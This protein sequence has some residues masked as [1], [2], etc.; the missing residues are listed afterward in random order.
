MERGATCESVA[1]ARR[2][3]V[4]ASWHDETLTLAF[5][6]G[7]LCNSDDQMIDAGVESRSR[8]W[9]YTAE[10]TCI[11]SPDASGVQLTS[12]ETTPRGRCLRRGVAL[13]LNVPL[14][15]DLY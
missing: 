15:L 9:T 8:S 10:T 6:A 13:S 11:R 1:S 5:F 7:E 12:T 4:I 2:Q 3:P 14:R